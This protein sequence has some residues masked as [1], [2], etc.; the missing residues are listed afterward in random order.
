MFANLQ[1][2]TMKSFQFIIAG[3]AAFLFAFAG[4]AAAEGVLPGQDLRIKV[5]SADNG[6]EDDYTF[7]PPFEIINDPSVTFIT[8]KNDPAEPTLTMTAPSSYS[9][10]VSESAQVDACKFPF[11][12][13][14]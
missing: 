6:L 5:A 14:V 7:L 13:R 9:V 8:V 10:V 4:M 1:Q 12:F 3:V 2:S 11:P